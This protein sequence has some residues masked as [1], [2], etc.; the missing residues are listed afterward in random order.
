V[1]LHGHAAFALGE[2]GGA[3]GEAVP[4]LIEAMQSGQMDVRLQAVLALGKMGAPAKSAIPAL[5]HVRK[6]D[7]SEEIRTL[8]T[9]SM[10][11][12]QTR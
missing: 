7:P 12:L 3:A 4:A 2:M 8:A 10:N 1:A 5:D 11:I 9:R 6:N